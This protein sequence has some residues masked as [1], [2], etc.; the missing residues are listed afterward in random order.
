MGLNQVPGGLI[1]LSDE[2]VGLPGRSIR[3]SDAPVALT[4]VEL[5]LPRRLWCIEMRLLALTQ[6]TAPPSLFQYHHNII[7]L[8]FLPLEGVGMDITISVIF[9]IISLFIE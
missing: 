6:R 8:F 3:L 1:R 5:L 4:H 7:V 2:H 9:N